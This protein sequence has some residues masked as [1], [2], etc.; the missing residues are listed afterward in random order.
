MN[1]LVVLIVFAAIAAG[2]LF[3]A[4]LKLSD[5]GGDD[6]PW[7][8]DAVKAMSAP[9]QVLYHRLCKTLPDNLVL[10]QVGLSRFLRVQ[11]GNN[12]QQWFNRINRMSADFVV[13]A[14]DASVLAVIELDDS[15]HE[16]QQNKTA[17]A[18]KDKA[19]AAAGIRIVRWNVKSLPDDA[20]IKATFKA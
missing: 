2:L 7:P 20:A 16:G 18:K 13:C 4:K 1:S 12:F 17:D 3:L 14:R 9:E 10:A 11:K 19:L 5:R 15:S 6:G 8:S